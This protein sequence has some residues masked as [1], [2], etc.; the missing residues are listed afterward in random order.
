MTYKINKTDGNTLAD[1]PDG[2]FD[3]NSSSLTL[4]G[5][6]VTNFGKIFNENLVKLLENFSSSTSPEHPIKG[7]L[8][9][10]TT[11]ARINVYDGNVFRASGG[12]LISAVQ[13]L[14]LVP[15]DLWINNETNQLYFYDGV[16]LLLAGPAYSAQQKTSGFIVDSI[17]DTNN[18]LKVIT[19]LFVNGVLI[20][21]FSNTAFTPALPITGFTGSIGIGFTVGNLTGTKFDVTVSRAEGLITAAGAVKVADDILYN[22]EDGTIVGSLKVQSVDGI[23]LLGGDPNQNPRV[24]GDASLKL[25]GGNFVIANNESSRAIEIKVLP[26]IG[27]QVTAMYVDAVNQRIG[28]FNSSPT[29]S[30]DITGDLKVSGNLIIQGDSFTIN[31]TTLEVEDKNIELNKKSTQVTDS[32]ADGGGITLKGTTDKT[33]AWANSTSAWTSNQ[34]I[35]LS[36][37]RAYHINQQQVLNGTTIGSSVINSNLQTLGN[38]TEAN[39]NAGLKISGNTII[40]RFTGNLKLDSVTDSIDIS[41]KRLIN[42]AG[43]DYISSSPS[44]VANKQYVDERVS[45][46]PIGLTADIS[47]FNISTQEGI[48]A[49][50]GK[51]L[52]ILNYTVSVFEP[53]KNPQGV[54]ILGT[55]AKVHA[56]HS[57]LSIGQISYNPVQEGTAT[58]SNETTAFRRV[59]VNR[60]EGSYDNEPVVSDIITGQV[61]PAPTAS[62]VVTRFYK[63][64]EVKASPSGAIWTFITDYIPK[65]QWSALTSY[66]ARDLVLFE[67]REY[68]CILAVSGNAGNTN[69]STDAGPTGTVGTIWKWFS[70]V[71]ISDF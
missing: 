63:R 71:D 55:I 64:F 46:R 12:P 58:T 59:S 48:D 10:D 31:T 15:G 41:G 29:A 36:S 18:R 60:G 3:T 37:G 49:A 6:N 5:K 2:T 8:W 69:P 45:I 70:T 38:L 4:I 23:Q 21:I 40:S 28:F 7:Q 27:G 1:I 20:G 43:L 54:A 39:F 26:S 51:I 57:A 11:T 53:I 22:N 47:D 25:N 17:I 44:E 14:N 13:P 52:E 35:D 67:N 50:T 56:T 42:L 33:F 65:G 62:V 34:N 30:V 9:Y 24:Q 66:S 16:D 68:I 61:I 19:K 32:S